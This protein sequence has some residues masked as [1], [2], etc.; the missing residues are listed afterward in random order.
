[1]QG[2]LLD[3][4]EL[5]KWYP[6]KQGLLAHLAFP[7]QFIKAVDGVTFRIREG[8]VFGLI[9]ESG[10]GK[11]TIGRT[12]LGLEEP[13]SG[14]ILF[15]GVE[16]VGKKSE[17]ER[18]KIRREFGAIFQDPY[19]SL[20]PKM[21]VYAIVSEPLT[22]HCKGISRDLM[23]CQVQNMLEE[24]R[25]S[26]ASDFIYKYPHELSGG[27]RQRVALARALILKPALIVADEPL[28]MLDV[29]L[30]SDML[31]LMS[32]MK[33]RY[34]L[35]YLFISHDLAV[36]KYFCD[37]IAVLYRGRVVE[38]APADELLD[39]PQHP[40]T[41]ALIDAVP[42]IGKQAKPPN[43]DRRYDAHLIVR[44]CAFSPRC[45]ISCEACEVSVPSLE[46]FRPG[47]SVACF[48]TKK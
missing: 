13:T 43:T 35:T 5:R 28:S 16:T 34:G 27:Q 26:P 33:S 20:N 10:S 24:M 25:L 15:R 41:K 30:R 11:T 1:M 12:I 23:L 46:E 32:E 14:E 40:Y 7:P 2:P 39:N 29:S 48:L 42:Q 17:K 37:R 9:G 21:N 45:P 19:D 22:I 6:L 4:V 44:G 18:K 8:E 3:V 36:S 31:R 38:E 47:H